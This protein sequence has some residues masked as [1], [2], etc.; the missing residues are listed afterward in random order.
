MLNRDP[1]PNC[2][3]YLLILAENASLLPGIKPKQVSGQKSCLAPLSSEMY[4]FQLTA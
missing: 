1:L 3:D 4:S 2:F